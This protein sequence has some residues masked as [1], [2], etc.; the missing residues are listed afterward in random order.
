M[1]PTMDLYRLLEDEHIILR[2]YN[3]KVGCDGLYVRIRSIPR[4]HIIIAS[5]ILYDPVC[6]RAVLAHE[7]G[8]HFTLSETYALHPMSGNTVTLR[9]EVRAEQWAIN[10]MVC[11][12]R[13]R[14]LSGQGV[15]TEEIAR[16][17]A[18]PTS[19]VEV[20]RRLVLT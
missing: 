11:P 3:L 17:L 16:R 1:R 18:V 14:V 15:D 5:R 2:I 12:E 13:I 6:F 9:D 19:W 8:H 4:P 7:L 20:M 10:Y